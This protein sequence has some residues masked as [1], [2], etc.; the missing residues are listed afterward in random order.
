MSKKRTNKVVCYIV[1][2]EHVI[3]FTH[4]GVPLEE[5]GVQVPAGTIK[6]SERPEDAAL[7]EAREETGL[8]DLRIV[9]KLGETDYDI[10]PYRHEIMHRHFFELTTD[11]PI[12]EPW[13]AGEPDPDNGAKGPTWTCR[14]TALADAHALACGLSVM[15]GSLIPDQEPRPSPLD[16]E[17]SLPTPSS[18]ASRS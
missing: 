10:S 1:R 3:T 6:P 8:A 5:V 2:D 14:W 7:R 13:Q 16:S 4:D 12:N 9:R 11:A 15:I 18:C 17:R